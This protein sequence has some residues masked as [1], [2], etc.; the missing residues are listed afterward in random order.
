MTPTKSAFVVLYDTSGSC[1]LLLDREPNDPSFT[2]WGFPGGKQDPEDQN[3]ILTTAYRELAEETGITADQVRV[4]ATLPAVCSTS[5]R[6]GNQYEITPVV[7]VLTSLAY[8]DIRL[9]SEHTDAQWLSV[10]VWLSNWNMLAGKA[11]RI[12]LEQLSQKYLWPIRTCYRM[13]PDSP[14]R[15]AAVRS[16]DVHAGVDLY[17]ELGTEVQAMCP[18]TVV[19]IENFTG[20]QVGQKYQYGDGDPSMPQP[21]SPW[22]NDTDAVLVQS[23]TDGSVI[24]YGELEADPEL[25]VGAKIEQGQLLGVIKKAVLKSN[26]GRPMVMLHLEYHEPSG[27]PESFGWN[28]GCPKPNKLRD[29]EILLFLANDS[30]PVPEFQLETY[31]GNRFINPSAVPKPSKWWAVWRKHHNVD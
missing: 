30:K 29:P 25:R 22:W 4:I 15:F 13:L 14:G 27:S 17:C 23:D 6:S 9:S 5:P 21:P 7:M 26:K 10:A 12:V 2:G 28:L 20:K 8:P 19:A 24:L 1:V 11:T 31:D 3:D 16:E 18:G